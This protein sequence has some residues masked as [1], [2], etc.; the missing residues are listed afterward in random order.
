MSISGEMT[1]I[2][3]KIDNLGDDMQWMKNALIEWAKAIEHDDKAN[4]LIQKYCKEDQK[5][6]DVRLSIETTIPKANRY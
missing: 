6:A 4:D 1:Q 2:N 5:Q 3:E